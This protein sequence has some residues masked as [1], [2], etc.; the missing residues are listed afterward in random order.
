MDYINLPKEI[1]SHIKAFVPRDKDMKHPSAS[2]LKLPIEWWNVLSGRFH[3]T[4]YI[5]YPSSFPEFV[6]HTPPIFMHYPPNHDDNDDDDD[7]VIDD[8]VSLAS[9]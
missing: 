1:T 7:E 5:L 2:S 3:N 6:L 8:I 4:G 9:F